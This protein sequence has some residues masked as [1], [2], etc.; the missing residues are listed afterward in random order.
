MQTETIIAKITPPGKSGIGVIRISGF[1]VIKIAKKI[2]QKKLKPRHAHH[3]NFFDITGKVIDQGIA[4]WFPKPHSF[5]GE[6]VLELQ[7]HGGE[8]VLNLIVTNILKFP[9]IRLAKPGEFSERAFLNN[10]IDLIQAEAIADLIN[11]NSEFAARSAINSLQGEF[12]FFINNLLKEI[13]DLRTHIEAE[14]DF[15][16]EIDIFLNKKLEKKIKNIISSLK[17]FKKKC[18]HINNISKGIK[19]AIV[20]PPNT[21]KSSLFNRLLQREAAIVS[22]IAGTTRDLLHENIYIN[23]MS[24]QIIDTAGFHETSDKIEKIGMLRA[25]EMIKNAD[26]ILFIID[27]DINFYKNIFKIILKKVSK[28]IPIVIIRNKIDL[29]NRC[30]KIETLN[31]YLVIH[32]SAHTGDGLKLLYDFF[33]KSF[34]PIEN[35]ILARTRHITALRSVLKHMEKSLHL[36]GDKAL[37]AEEFRL[38][39]L[40]LNEITGKFTSDDLLTNIFSNFCIGK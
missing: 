7:G 21:G 31:D 15:S 6:D 22:D 36:I 18:F 34:N 33:K 17:K 29:I 1:N 23:N 14:I 8:V 27:Q 25:S 9:G 28:K 26:Q 39:Q 30:A 5:T 24:F 12:S 32:L 10:K 16:E 38:S 3:T 13:I 20:G 40:Y 37:V 4:I 11:A 35:N 2:I 19:I